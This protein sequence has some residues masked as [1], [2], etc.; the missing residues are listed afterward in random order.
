MIRAKCFGAKNPIVSRYVDF[1]EKS[2]LSTYFYVHHVCRRVYTPIMDTTITRCEAPATNPVA[3]AP[4]ASVALSTIDAFG[5][6][7]IISDAC[8]PVAYRLEC[9]HTTYTRILAAL[10]SLGL[11]ITFTDS[12]FGGICHVWL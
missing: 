12:L 9:N 5:A 6:V 1:L 4:R 2:T 11:W 3:A 7:E 8:G 10:A